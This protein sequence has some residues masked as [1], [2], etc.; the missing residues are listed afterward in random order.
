M[1]KRILLIESQKGVVDYIITKL[2]SFW[3]PFFVLLL[4]TITL[5]KIP[6][7][8]QMK[9]LL[10]QIIIYIWLVSMFIF[11]L[12]NIP[13][14]KC[15][16]ICFD[17]FYDNKN[18]IHYTNFTVNRTNFCKLI[19]P[20]VKDNHF[21]FNARLYDQINGMAMGSL[22]SLTLANYQHFYVHPGNSLL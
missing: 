9:F 7:P 16:D 11:D 17:L 6:S 10:S 21:I 15:N 18:I 19:N 8:L 12:T 3:S 13:L 22:L 20:A 4:F 2:L 5:L 14:D 1:W